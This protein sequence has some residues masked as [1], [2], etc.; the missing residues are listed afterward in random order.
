MLYYMHEMQRMMMAPSRMLAQGARLAMRNP[1]N[2]LAYTNA[3]RTM[4]STADLFEHLTRRFGK[5]EWDLDTTV[6]DGKEVDVEY[7]TVVHR[8]F[9]HLVHFK[10][11]LARKRNDPKLLIVA[12]LSGHYATL[13]RGTVEEMIP[14]HEV[15]IT[16]W[17]D[18]RMIPVTED[19]FNLND[20]ID[21][22][23]DFLHVLGPN[24][25]VIAVCQPAVPSLAATAIMSGWG[26]LCAPAT[27][28]M[29]G[30][31]IDTRESPTAVNKL[32]KEHTIE[33]FERNVI[34]NVPL[35]YPGAM[36]KVY[37]G[38]IQLTNFI[39]MN[40]DRHLASYHELFDHLVQGDDDAAEKKIAFYEEYRAVMDLPA[41][42][43]LQTVKTVFQ[44]HALPKGEMMA[45]WH[46][47]DVG[48]ID[49]TALLC[50]EG[51]LDDISGVGQTKAAL[52]LATGLSDDKKLYHLQKAAGHYG[53]FN[54]SKWRNQIAPV[55]KKWIRTHDQDLQA[56]K[57]AKKA[58]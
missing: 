25:H 34:V 31:P 57:P 45:R 3:G 52:K 26:D 43:Y 32:A 4:M 39:S 28:T 37:P 50:V 15:Y 7:E 11:K 6:I 14:D 8:T 30:G 22:L 40:L 13:L 55:V 33:W 9:C 51:E 16:D 10:R 2:P 56:K 49:R 38:F 54:G 48:K 20:Y 36:R 27:L 58:A 5:P 47:V 19:K 35:P 18:P 23:V 41:E 42:Y 24:T 29:M 17:Q 44:D 46:P 12:P 21:Y 1:M 53:I